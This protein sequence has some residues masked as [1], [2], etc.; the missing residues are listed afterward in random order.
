MIL[1]FVGTFIFG[2]QTVH[3][4]TNNLLYDAFR[5]S[6]EHV[7]LLEDISKH[8]LIILTGSKESGLFQFA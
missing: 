3:N 5:E 1:A 4:D 8:K 6:P 7:T 2:A